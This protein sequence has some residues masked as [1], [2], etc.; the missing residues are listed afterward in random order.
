MLQPPADPRGL[1]DPSQATYHFQQAQNGDGRLVY[2]FD[3]ASN[4]AFLPGPA[5]LDQL[6]AESRW[7]AGGPGRA[8]VTV[9]GGDFQGVA[10]VHCWDRGFQTVF[11]TQLGGM[12]VGD[13]ASCAYPAP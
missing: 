4:P 6:T 8:D 11:A 13:V 1:G 5:G 12:D 10:I 2:G 3:D 9:T 7:Q